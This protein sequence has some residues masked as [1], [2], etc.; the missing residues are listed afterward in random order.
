MSVVI[1]FPLALLPYTNFSFLLTPVLVK[2]EIPK[3]SGLSGTQT[4]YLAQW[5][6]L[7]AL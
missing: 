6:K 7:A 2:H 5:P 3:Q 4:V 1:Q